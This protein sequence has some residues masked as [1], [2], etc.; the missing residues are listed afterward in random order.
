MESAIKQF[1][2]HEFGDS[3]VGHDFAGWEVRKG[4]YGQEG[5]RFGW[6]LDHILPKSMGGT[7]DM[8][9]LQIT[10]MATN[11]ERGNKVTFWLNDVPEQN[12]VP[13]QISY[14]VKR[15]SRLSDDDKEADYC[16]HY[17]GKKYCIVVVD[18]VKKEA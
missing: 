7:D 12:G 13:V 11:S 5:S 18:I 2:E 3:E 1:W 16:N 14:Q 9:N 6:N 10:H 4:A 17:E 15:V 8:N